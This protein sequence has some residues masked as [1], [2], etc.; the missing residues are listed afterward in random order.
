MRPELQAE[1]NQDINW[2]SES[3]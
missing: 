3:C 1:R 2:V